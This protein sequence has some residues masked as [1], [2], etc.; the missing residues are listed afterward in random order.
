MSSELNVIFVS[1]PHFEQHVEADLPAIINP[2]GF[3]IVSGAIF[4]A[5][6]LWSS[7]ALRKLSKDI[8]TA[9]TQTLRIM[10]KAAWV[11]CRLISQKMIDYPM[12]SL[13]MALVA[14]SLALSPTLRQASVIAAGIATDACI[15]AAK[16]ALAL[17]KRINRI[18]HTF[19][20]RRPPR[21]GFFY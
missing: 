1:L 18:V 2:S 17:C 6:I 3:S 4:M 16:Y 14:V 9:V 20:E 12:P 15:I 7:P 8:G 11:R 10:C 19:F 5:V 21:S 13:G